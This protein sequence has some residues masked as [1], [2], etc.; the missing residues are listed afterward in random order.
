MSGLQYHFRPSAY[1]PPM[2][3]TLEE[4]KLRVRQ[5]DRSE[6]ALSYSD[7][8]RV[9]LWWK[10]E[11]GGGDQYLC[12][13]DFLL[14][15]GRTGPFA[16]FGSRTHLSGQHYEERPT[17]YRVFVEELHRRLLAAGTRAEFVTGLPD[18][19]PWGIFL[20]PA[21]LRF[22]GTFLVSRLVRLPLPI[23]LALAALVASI[24]VPGLV[25]GLERNRKGPYEPD[26]LPDWV[27]PPV[28]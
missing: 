7:V 9:R 27:L 20:R 25:Q 15:D 12:A 22:L 4:D 1:D 3:L 2:A 16:L 19:S 24:G 21:G 5:G 17:E 13:I 14:P 18:S 11:R 6:R 23:G 26:R 10:R 8:A 28:P